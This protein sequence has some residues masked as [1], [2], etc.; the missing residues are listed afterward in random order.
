MSALGVAFDPLFTL[1][2]FLFLE[3]KKYFFLLEFVVLIYERP[4]FFF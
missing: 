2:H 1:L 3:R 4:L